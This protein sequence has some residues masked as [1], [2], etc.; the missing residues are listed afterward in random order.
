[1]QR[2]IHNRRPGFFGRLIDRFR[3]DMLRQYLASA[4]RTLGPDAI[5]M[6]A[7][8]CGYYIQSIQA[9]DECLYIVAES[10]ARR[11]TVNAASLRSSLWKTIDFD[12]PE[13]E[14]EIASESPAATGS[15]PSIVSVPESVPAQEQIYDVPR[16]LSTFRGEVGDGRLP[17]AASS[18]ES[19]T[20]VMFTRK[21]EYLSIRVHASMDFE[22]GRPVPAPRGS[23]VGFPQEL[24][25][26][27]RSYFVEDE[28]A[29]YE[30]PD[31][32]AICADVATGEVHYDEP[33]MDSP[34]S[35]AGAACSDIKAE[36]VVY[37]EPAAELP[38]SDG[39]AVV[40]CADLISEEIHVS[41]EDV[42]VVYTEEVAVDMCRCRYSACDGGHPLVEMLI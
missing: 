38:G 9:R 42:V 31:A 16:S 35:N 27:G 11:A 26:L 8:D 22:A 20:E 17:Y 19:V 39:G 36:E 12:G 24:L 3:T 2:N 21:T 13:L 37:D 32:I 14:L 28:E 29:I 5:F 30:N 23:Y 1:M 4:M 34:G 10:Q 33:A 6:L 7:A 18:M 41:T 25:A 40:V 15:S